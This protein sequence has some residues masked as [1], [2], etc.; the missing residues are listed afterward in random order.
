MFRPEVDEIAGAKARAKLAEKK[1]I[2]EEEKQKRL[3]EQQEA[4]EAERL[5][6][7]REQAG[8]DLCIW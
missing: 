3:K 1:R 6:R 8:K 5:Q 4:E 7:I 2:E